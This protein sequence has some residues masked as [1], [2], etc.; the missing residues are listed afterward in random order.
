[1]YI[2]IDEN[3]KAH[4][5]YGG[6]DTNQEFKLGL[7]IVFR[8]AEDDP[9]YYFFTGGGTILKVLESRSINKLEPIK[10]LIQSNEDIKRGRFE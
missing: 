7:P 1:M 8:R 10:A 3:K 5:L 2:A 9:N 4:K 6:G